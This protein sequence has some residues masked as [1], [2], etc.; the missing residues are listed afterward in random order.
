MTK[1]RP[2]SSLLAAM[3]GPVFWAAH[4]FM[5]Y[6]IEAFLCGP[7]G[8]GIASVR[9]AAAGAT[10][11]AIAV[12]IWARF[13]RWSERLDGTATSFIIVRPLI[14]LSVVAIAWTALPILFLRACASAGG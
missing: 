8:S 3:I 10:V 4:F 11:L 5:V 14:D 6:F 13:A 12:L 1:T 7:G 2:L 9:P